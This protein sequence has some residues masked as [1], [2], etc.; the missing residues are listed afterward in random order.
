MLVSLG[1]AVALSV[2]PTLTPICDQ[3]HESPPR[4]RRQQTQLEMDLQNRFDLA[5]MAEKAQRR[6]NDRLEQLQWEIDKT[7]QETETQ[8]TQLRL[9]G[10]NG[11]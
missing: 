5:E 4:H 8:Q 6:T 2:S 3:E 11:F 9:H 1:L 10:V 7:R